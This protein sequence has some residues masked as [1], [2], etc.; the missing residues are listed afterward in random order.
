MLLNT[1]KVLFWSYSPPDYQNPDG[2]NTAL[3]YIWNPVKRT[4]HSITPP[5]NIWCGGQTIRSDGRVYAGGQATLSGPERAGW[6]E[7]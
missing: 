1:G 6:T 5:E 7:G 3:A 2:S 4:G